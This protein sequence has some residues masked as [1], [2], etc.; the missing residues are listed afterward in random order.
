MILAE[1]THSA[2][3]VLLLM[4]NY[5]STLPRELE[6]AAQVDGCGRLQ[7]ALAH[8]AAALAARASSRA[9]CSPSS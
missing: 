2:P 5:F 6:E 8:R 3:F 7:H 4:I 9:G 1:A